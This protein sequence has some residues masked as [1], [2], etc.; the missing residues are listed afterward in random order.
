LEL[1]HTLFIKPNNMFAL[2]DC[3]NF[4]ASCEKIF[5]PKLKNKAVAVLSNNDGC[6]IARSKEAKKLNIEMGSPIFKYK[7]LVQ[8][9]I[10]HIFSSNFVL[11][12]DMSK[13]VMQTLKSFL[14][15]MEIYSID[16]AFLDLTTLNLNYTELLN[17]AAQIKNRIYKW[18]N[19]EVSVGIGK[20]KT[21]AK[22][23]NK[24]AKS[25][26]IFILCGNNIEHILK[27]TDLDD[28]W[29]IN[30]NLKKRLYKIGIY[31]AFDLKNANPILLKK[32]LSINVVKISFELNEKK[33]LDINEN[34][35][36]KKSICSSRSFAE[37][38]EN[39]NDLKKSLCSF[40]AIATKKL[41]EQRQKANFLSVFIT[42]SFH[43]DDPFYSNSYQLSLPFA[44]SYTPD[45]LKYATCA[46]KKIYKK[47][48]LYKKTGIIL[49]SFTCE[50]ALQTDFF[51]PLPN[52]KKDALMKTLDSINKKK[53]NSIFFA[54]EK[55]DQKYKSSSKML[56]FKFTTSLDELLIVK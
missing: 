35:R 20:T 42:T 43:S 55:I 6:I 54:S 23:A 27:K 52:F 13:R 21:L 8:N 47:N 3:N 34:F 7:D 25:K 37:K 46:L 5:N 38:I 15:P 10:L 44:T 11:Y 48:Y 41:R 28:I 26:G 16:E 50:N 2:I 51:R 40:A 32:S 29:G 33:C 31:S 17:L 53:K 1:F 45:I 36:N 24:Q 18:T 14:I 4:Y 49:S 19:I 9:N 22:L 30:K 56:S 39:F 12:G